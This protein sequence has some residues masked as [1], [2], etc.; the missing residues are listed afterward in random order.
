MAAAGTHPFSH[1]DEQR[2]TPKNRYRGLAEDYQQLAREQII[3]GCNVHVGISNKEAAIQTM[4]RAGMWLAPLV[5]LTANSPFWLGTDSGYASFGREMWRRW[6]MAGI[7]PQFES[8]ADYDELMQ[9]LIEADVI[10]DPTKIYWDMRPS[11]PF[12]TL[13]FRVTD[14]CMTIDEAVMVTGLTRGLA[15][16]CYEHAQS[17]RPQPSI[18]AELLV[19]AKWRASRYGLEGELIDLEART[20]VSAPRAID[21]LFR[22]HP[23]RPGT[24]G[25]LARGVIPG[26]ANTQ[27]RNGGLAPATGAGPLWSS[28]RRC[29]LDRLRDGRRPC[30]PTEKRLISTTHFVGFAG[31]LPRP[32]LRW[33]P[34]LLPGI[35]RG[36]RG[37]PRGAGDGLSPARLVVVGEIA[38]IG[39]AV[40]PVPELRI[41]QRLVLQSQV[42]VVV[43]LRRIASNPMEL[44]S[45]PDISGPAIRRVRDLHVDRSPIHV[46]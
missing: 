39:V 14:V 7:P 33:G 31:L 11:T 42:E 18:P 2:L 29:G 22:F 23:S 19:A 34:G 27:K 26:E 12:D 30:R 32:Y 21:N 1:W 5:A 17:H 41:G 4:N 3:C 40:G 28:G 35:A 37:G 13:E 44:G 43:G 15:R 46:L 16:S 6:P 36:A 9:T 38:P 45:L 10:K 8:R 20:T 25:R 24:R